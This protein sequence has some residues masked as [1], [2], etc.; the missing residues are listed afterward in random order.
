MKVAVLVSG[1]GTNLQA[2]LDAQHPL[3]E[4]VLVLSDRKDA[5]ALERAERASIPTAIVEW[6][7]DGDR[8]SFTKLVCDRIEASGAELI[9]L[10][11]FMRVLSP[12]A[13]E[14]FPDRIL[15]LHP[16]LLPAFP[17]A[18]AVRDTLDYGVRITGVTVHL[19]DEE[20]DHGPVVSQRAIPV[21]D[22]DDEE[23]LHARIHQVEYELYPEAVAAFAEGR[24]QVKG[25]KVI[26]T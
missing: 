18:H 25:R 2:I 3:V 10:A 15:N 6:P 23:T 21:Y 22:N 11:G 7:S 20:V 17:G 5:F 1:S 26:W 8:E 9:V 19:I 12:L 24:I 4:P 13:V 14:R 16:A